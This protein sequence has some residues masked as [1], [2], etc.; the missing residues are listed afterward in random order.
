M[1]HNRDYYD[2]PIRNLGDSFVKQLEQ[3]AEFI[4]RHMLPFILQPHA[5][6]KAAPVETNPEHKLEN[7]IGV[8][9]APPATQPGY[10]PR[11]QKAR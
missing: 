6:K 3:E 5:G 1:V 8:T 7:F 9:K 11:K 2:R 10:K 4:G